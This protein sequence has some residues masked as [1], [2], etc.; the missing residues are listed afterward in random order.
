[1]SST[2]GGGRGLF[3]RWH[4]FGNVL[5]QGPAGRN[6]VAQVCALGEV[7]HYRGDSLLSSLKTYNRSK[8]ERS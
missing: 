6:S 2:S 8:S 1:M 7:P 4:P 5:L 3:T